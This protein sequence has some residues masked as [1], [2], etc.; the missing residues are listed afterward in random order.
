[1]STAAVVLAAGA[2]RRFRGSS[3]KLLAV[4]DG[5]ALVDH[6]LDA[7]CAAEF[8]FDELI[9]V[10]GAVDLAA[11][12]PDVAPV[13]YIENLRW[14]EGIATSLQAA[15]YEAGLGSGHDAI[16]VGLADQPGVPPEAWTAVA[17]ETRTPI[18][19]ATYDGTRGNPVRLAKEVWSLLPEEGDEGA[20]AV[21]RARPELVT[22]VPCSGT[23]FDIDTTE[24]LR[25]LG[26]TP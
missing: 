26:G 21:M 15:V 5:K 24:D 16:V 25:H 20:R 19:V 23:P 9:L 2:G 7:V 10:A 3:H 4:V 11:H 8:V 14:Q 13:S 17:A 22:E 1:V 6:V 12:I 18:A